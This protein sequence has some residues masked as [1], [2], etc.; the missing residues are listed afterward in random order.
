MVLTQLEPQCNLYSY[1]AHFTLA[2]IP[3]LPYPICLLNL[4]FVDKTA[5]FKAA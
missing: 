4:C 3:P 5:H 1:V 2:A